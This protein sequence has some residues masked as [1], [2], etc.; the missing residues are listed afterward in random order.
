LDAPT[1]AKTVAFVGA[2]GKT[3]AIFQLARELIQPVLVTTTTHL[4]EWQIPLADHHIVAGQISDIAEREFQGVTLITGPIQEGKVTSIDGSIL[5]WLHAYSQKLNIPLLIEADGSHQKALKAPNEHEPVI[6]EF[7]ETVI[8]MA[9]LSGLGKPLS[10][11]YTHR[12]EFFASLSGLQLNDPITAD[13]L[14]RVLTHPNGGLKNIP[15]RA[16]RIVFLNQADTP[17]LQSMGGRMSAP[18][19][20]HFD[21]VIVG[22]LKN[23]IYQTF[24]PTAGIILAAGAS[25]RFGQPKQLL[26][27]RGEPFIR[28]VA[29]TALE[30]GLSPVIVVT[31]ANAEGVEA[32]VRDLPVIIARNEDWQSGQASSIRTGLQALLPPYS[33]MENREETIKRQA[34]SAIFLLADQPHITTTVIRALIEHH[35]TELD[36]IVAPLVMMEQR[37]NPVLFDRVTF[38]DLMKLEG[39]IGG[40]AIFSKY[41]VEYLPWH[42][43]RLLLDVDKPE[44]YQRLIEDDML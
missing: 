15:P 8:V 31:G 32:A 22:S 37:A 38:P 5:S 13:A 27:W 35:T 2:G 25:T 39:D 24:E 30:V 36:P 21:S 10:T 43:D 23:S 17:D 14:T 7:V 28:A 16:H 26:D 19:L 33:T 34:G 11:E 9:G 6:P 12:P 3:T 20:E 40:R 29:R 4:G 44:D 1:K 41:P 18:L 42:D